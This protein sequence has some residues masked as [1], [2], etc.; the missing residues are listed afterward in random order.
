M[1]VETALRRAILAQVREQLPFDEPRTEYGQQDGFLRYHWLL[2]YL[3][4][5][6]HYTFNRD[7]YAVFTPDGRPMVPQVCIDFITHTLERAS[8]TWWNA[9]GQKPG[10]KVGGWDFDAVLPN[11]RTVKAFLR[12]A[13]DN[14]DVFDTFRVP[15]PQQVP[16]KFRKRFYGFLARH[17]DQFQRGDVVVILGYAP[18]DFHHVPH[19][20]TFFVYE[21]DPMTGMPILLAGNAGK[22]RV[23]SWDAV[24]ARTPL[25]SI[26]MRVRPR[27]AWLQRIVD[28]PSEDLRVPPPLVTRFR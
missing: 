12:Y 1:R 9:R 25:R 11:R 20:H 14:P 7:R 28:D 24:M 4:G 17:V 5:K 16:Y 23:Q 18:W 27:H 15:R 13:D 3:E 26:R 22:P 10:R 19:Y 6:D 2:A 21:S 8:G